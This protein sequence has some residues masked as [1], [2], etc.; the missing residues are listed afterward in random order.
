VVRPFPEKLRKDIVIDVDEVLMKFGEESRN[1]TLLQ[2]F[3]EL[4]SHVSGEFSLFF[5]PFLTSFFSQITLLVSL[6]GRELEPVTIVA[7]T[8]IVTLISEIIGVTST[9]GTTPRRLGNLIQ[10]DE[11]SVGAVLHFGLAFALST[12]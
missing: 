12:N 10:V 6:T 8:T 9:G 5:D 3:D 4:G 7:V 2:Q 1:I 11:I